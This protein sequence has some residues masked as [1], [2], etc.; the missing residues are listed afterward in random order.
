MKTKLKD[1]PSTREE[2]RPTQRVA[3]MSFLS[4]DDAGDGAFFYDTSKVP[5]GYEYAWR[6]VTYAGK[7]DVRH[8]ARMFRNLWTAVPKKRH[9][10]VIGMEAAKKDPEGAIVIDGQM[11]ME[12]SIIIN[13]EARRRD[14]KKAKDRVNNQIRSLRLTPEKQLPRS[15]ARLKRKHDVQVAEPDEQSVDDED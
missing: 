9:P 4:E 6:R 13:D 1:R 7:E 15:E 10:E 11:L 8:Q 14:T 12:R 5:D 3:D 2:Q